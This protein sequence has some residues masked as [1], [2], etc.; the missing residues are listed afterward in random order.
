MTPWP[1]QEL[2]DLASKHANLKVSFTLDRAPAKWA[3]F[4]GFVTSDM[5]AQSM[6]PAGPSVQ[7]LVCGPPAMVKYACKPAFEKL[8][9]R[10]SNIMIW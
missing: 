2:E 9:Y 8:G 5:L 3:H 7:M 10:D 6:P 1:P 4:T